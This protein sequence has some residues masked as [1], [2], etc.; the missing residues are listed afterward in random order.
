M[1][2]NYSEKKVITKDMLDLTHENF[3]CEI[4]Y[5]EFEN[6]DWEQYVQ[7]YIDLRQADINN[8]E[9]AWE[10]WI[11]YGLFENRTYKKIINDDYYNFD[12]EQYLKNYPDLINNGINTKDT[13]W[14]HWTKYGLYEGRT[15][16][17]LLVEK[18]KNK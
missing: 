13:A 16:G 5:Q 12:W 1:S 2:I 8:M 17:N 10:H 15:H 18:L 7:N 9:K 6:F 4:Y 14:N 11:T 3:D